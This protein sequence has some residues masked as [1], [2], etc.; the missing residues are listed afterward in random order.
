MSQIILKILLLI[1]LFLAAFSD[2]RC[3]E[4]S[5]LLV[6]AEFITGVFFR[7]VLEKSNIFELLC[8]CIP[9]CVFLLFSWLTKQAV[10]Y[11]DSAMLV[12]T[13]VFLGLTRTLLLLGLSFLAAGLF[14]A[15]KLIFYKMKRKE[16]LPFLPFLLTG[17]L[18]LLAIG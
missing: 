1:F 18:G 11:G 7:L 5:L 4:I 14:A 16:E 12:S 17:Y 15:V 8:G 2:V 10:G 3:G 6:G 13:G 9:G